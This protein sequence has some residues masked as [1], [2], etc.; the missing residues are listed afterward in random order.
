MPAPMV[1]ILMYHSIAEAPGATSIAPEIFAAQMQ[2]IA[3]TGV[4][5]I[6]LDDLLAARAG[7]RTLAPQSVIITFDDGFRDFSQNACPVLEKHG[8]SAI[9][10]LPSGQVGR[11]ERWA[12]AHEPPR[13]LMSWH[14]IRRH[15][16]AG[17]QFGSHTVTHPDLTGLDEEVLAVE[18]ERSRDDIQENLGAPVRHFA[19]PYGLAGRREQT[20]IARLYKTSVGTRLGR[21]SISGEIYDLPRL[22]MFYFSD[23]G[24]WR[25]HLTGR[26]GG[27]LR[28]RKLLRSVRQ[29]LLNPWQ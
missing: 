9:V 6:T 12:G 16:N 20:A 13:E 7:Q 17:I 22:E 3:E 18:L 14:E 29:T 1:D 25:S 24:R 21:A 10:Y 26:G 4:P 5:V 19:P 15:A 2:A 23:I 8:F 27:Y 28:T 11:R